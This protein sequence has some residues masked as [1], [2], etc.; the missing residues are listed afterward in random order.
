MVAEY[1]HATSTTATSTFAGGLSAAGATGLTVLQNGNVGVGN[2]SPAFNLDVT[3][4]INV[5][6]LLHFGNNATAFDTT[7]THPVLYSTSNG[8]GV[9]PFLTAGNLVLQSRP[10]GASRDIVLSRERL[11]RREW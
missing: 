8:G 7:D 1:F 3:G 5:A 11:L 4:N 6:T 9:Y 2:T 10:S